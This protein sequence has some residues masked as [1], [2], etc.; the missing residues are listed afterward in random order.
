MGNALRPT[1]K[2]RPISLFFRAVPR[3]TD[4]PCSTMCSRDG[5][6]VLASYEEIRRFAR[7]RDHEANIASPLYMGLFASEVKRIPR[8]AALRGARADEMTSY[9]Q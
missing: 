3:A 7:S 2:R 8:R 4:R 6:P 5:T 1:V 9:F